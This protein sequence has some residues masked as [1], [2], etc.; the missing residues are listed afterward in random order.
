MRQWSIGFIQ[1]ALSGMGL[2]TLIS[3]WVLAH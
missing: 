2:I 1:G 3:I